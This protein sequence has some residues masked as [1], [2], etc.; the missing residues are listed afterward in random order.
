MSFAKPK[1]GKEQ[2]AASS[3]KKPTKP[4]EGN[5]IVRIIP[6]IKK[7]AD[8]G[9]WSVYHKVHWGYSVV[10]D[11][12][13]SKL[14]PRPFACTEIRTKEGLVK[15]E[16]AECKLIATQE[17]T[18]EI[19]KKELTVQGVP[20]EQQET[21][22]GPL[23][24]WLSGN[25]G[26]KLD[27]KHYLWVLDAN[28]EIQLLQLSHR[29]KTS[30][31]VAIEDLRKEG[32][33]PIDA[34]GGVLFNIIRVGNGYAPDTVKVVEENVNVGGRMLK[35]VKP[36]PLS[37]EVYNKVMAECLDLSEVVRN[38]TPAQIQ[39]I[40]DAGGAPEVVKAVLEKAEVAPEAS[41]EASPAPK[42]TVSLRDPAAVQTPPPAVLQTSPPVEHTAV[43]STV[44]PE[45]APTAQVVATP[46]PA[47]ATA[48]LEAALKAAT[49]NLSKLAGQPMDVSQFLSVF[50]GKK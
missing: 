22:L 27:N 46:S 5:N 4:K 19:R 28:N 48:D 2:N 25:G 31:D 49:E 21:L 18:L 47:A 23:N 1:Y 10:D 45:V 42:A 38:V 15:R 17:A 11:K 20:E 7:Q 43:A 14:R 33:D 29:T 34:E 13:P 37:V 40:V 41:S 35:A 9:R 8:R 39:A 12:D 6:P 36:A 32:V 16:C 50:G 24:E 3:Y 44:V 26:H 30:L